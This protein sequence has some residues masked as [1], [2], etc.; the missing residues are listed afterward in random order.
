MRARPAAE[1]MASTA[2]NECFIWGNPPLMGTIAPTPAERPSRGD[3]P[4]SRGDRIWQGK[5]ARKAKLAAGRPNERLFGSGGGGRRAPA[6]QHR[7]Y[8][9]PAVGP[10]RLPRGSYVRPNPLNS[11]GFRQFWS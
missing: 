10:R 5:R 11:A 1:T 4:L 9:R 2:V 3:V 6:L 8:L 7:R